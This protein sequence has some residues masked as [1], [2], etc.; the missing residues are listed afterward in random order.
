[1][2]A[3]SLNSSTIT[4]SPDFSLREYQEDAINQV[5]SSYDDGLTSVL[6]YAPTGAGKTV[7]AAKIIADYV[8]AG[9]RVLF[10]V[11]RGKLVRQTL[12]KLNKFF[13]IDAGV[14]WR[15]YEEPNYD[16]PVQIAMLQTI[17]NREL[18]PNIDLVILDE[19]HTGSYFQIWRQIMDYYSGGIWVLSKTQFLGLSASPWRSK[20][21]QGYC[22]F[23]Q[24]VV[25]APYPKELIEMGHLCRARQFGYTGLI[26]ESKLR[27]VDGEFTEASMRS[28]CTPALNNEIMKRYLERDPDLER[29]IIA[30][31]ATVEQ[32]QDLAKQFNSIGAEAECIVAATK[33]TTREEIFDNYREGKIKLLTSIFVLTEGF[34]E[35]SVTSV[36]VCRPVKSKALWVQM[37]GRGLRPLEGKQDCWFLDFCGNIQRLGLPTDSFP[38]DLCPDPKPFEPIS[39]KTCPQCSSEIAIFEAICPHCGYIFNFTK[40]LDVSRRKFEEILSPEQRQHVRFMRT[41]AVNAYKKNQPLYN[42]DEMFNNEFNYYPPLD[43]YDGLV[44]GDD[45]A[46]WEVNVQ[47]YWRYLLI[48]TQHLHQSADEAKEWIQKCIKREFKFKIQYARSN[49]IKSYVNYIVNEDKAAEIADAKIRDLISYKPWWAILRLE[50]APD[51]EYLDFAYKENRF[52]YEHMYGDKPKIMQAHMELLGMAIQEGIDYYS[53][54]AEVIEK[55]VSIISKAIDAGRFYVVEGYI[56]G[57]NHSERERIW[58]QLSNNQKLAYRHWQKNHQN[59]NSPIMPAQIPKI[60][61]YNTQVR[62]LNSHYATNYTAP[63]NTND[64]Q[65]QQQQ[66]PILNSKQQLS[67][68]SAKKTHLPGR[69]KVGDTVRYVGK[70][71]INREQYAGQLTVYSF[72]YGKVCILTPNGRI[73]TWLDYHEISKI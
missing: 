68:Q 61:T 39:T 18:P 73:S 15:D 33:E 19:A 10:L 56:R 48:A 42:L 45:L 41:R 36:L 27:V 54:D 3:K 64:K 16:K 21:N 65:Q 70:N 7:L 49:M 52:R 24:T 37:N 29:K 72:E 34:D 69:Y 32:A 44:F 12:D 13:G 71:S 17:C 6:L 8:Q 38:I 46:T 14:I 53:L 9:K 47:H 58:N 35:P 1:M 26:D 63:V 50:Q 62:S 60:L 20:S 11:H 55:H 28:V 57:L 66:Q 43:W 23:F 31:C 30:F 22:Q 5:Y 51:R 2:Q 40:K 67:T 59:I 25:K 4:I